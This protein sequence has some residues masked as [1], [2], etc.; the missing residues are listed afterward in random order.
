MDTW[1]GGML[2]DIKLKVRVKPWEK[3]SDAAG[4]NCEEERVH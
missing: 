3:M 4:R 2:S 1:R